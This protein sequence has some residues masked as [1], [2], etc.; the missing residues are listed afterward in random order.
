MMKR[1]AISFIL[2]LTLML[3][4]VSVCAG[5]AGEKKDLGS[6][7][8]LLFDGQPWKTYVVENK[9]D[10]LQ[11]EEMNITLIDSEGRPVSPDAYDLVVGSEVGWD[12]V[13]DCPITQDYDGDLTISGNPDTEQAGF[14]GYNLKAVAKK[15]SD[16]TGTTDPQEF[17]I[18]HRYSFNWFG[19]NATFGEEYKRQSTWSWHDYYLLPLGRTDAPEVLGAA[20]D[21][22]DPQYYT[23]TYFNRVTG[24]PVDNNPEYE[25]KVYP[26]GEDDALALDGMPTEAGAYFV[27]ITGVA[28]YYGQSFIDFDIVSPV[29]FAFERGD[30]RKYYDG[31]TVYLPE[32]GELYLGFDTE[33][34]TGLIPG[35]DSGALREQGFDID[36]DPVWFE[37][38]GYAYAHIKPGDVQP[39]GSGVIQYAWYKAEDL[40]GEHAVGWDKAVPLFSATVKLEVVKRMPELILGDADGSEDITILDA[41]A[42]QRYLVNLSAEGFR[43]LTADTN[44]NGNIDILDAT[45][46]QRWLVNFDDGTEIGENINYGVCFGV[47]NTEQELLPAGSEL[48]GAAAERAREEIRQA[49]NLLI[50]RNAV[51]QT[52]KEFNRVAATSLVP[53]WISDVDGK[54]FHKEY[55]SVVPMDYEANVAA[56]VETLKKYYTFDD[57]SGKFTDAPALSYFV[58]NVEPVTAAAEAIRQ[59]LENVGVE[60]TI[61]AVEWED[62]FDK[63]EAR[64][65][66]FSRLGWATVSDDPMV[67]L[68]GWV[69]EYN[70]AGLGRGVYADAEVYSLDLAPYGIEY[71]V[72]NATW[73][74]TYDELIC[75]IEACKD[76]ATAYALMHV[77][78]DMLMSTGCVIP[79]FYY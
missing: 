39:G 17:M 6:G 51:V 24:I 69:S 65:Y 34:Y 53:R 1:R 26:M 68:S 55:Y 43:L 2:A 76:P 59:S 47:W 44:R 30:E 42:I 38:D 31:D 60:L 12:E 58:N 13:K 79:L 75:R 7:Y 14:V 40:F 8:E 46:I 57:Q 41:T 16:Y 9:D 20:L 78:E 77:A 52:Q 61:D 73:A 72:E 23:L 64:N 66:S 4:V 63:M 11:L 50:D 67:F 35:W 10:V 3:S 36:L 21:G 49:I 32:D 5:A 25:A 37:E 29:S 19:A 54:P 45:L 56:A 74:Q 70:E 62:Y 28:P 71:Q 18:W 27:K 48:T 15:D 22:V 33:P